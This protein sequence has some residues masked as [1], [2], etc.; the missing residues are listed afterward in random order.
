[1]QKKDLEAARQNSSKFQLHPYSE[2]NALESFHE[3]HATFRLLVAI[4]LSL[5]A[6]NCFSE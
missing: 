6:K 3:V 2:L 4:F 1:M 5:A